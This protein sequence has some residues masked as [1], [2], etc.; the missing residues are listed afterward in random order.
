MTVDLVCIV[1][2]KSI[3][4]AIETLLQERK[5]SLGLGEFLFEIHVHPQR[6]PGCYKSGPEMLMSLMQQETTRGLLVFDHAWEGNPHPDAEATRLDVRRRLAALGDRAEVL[7]L[8]PELESWVWSG[9]PHVPKILGWSSKTPLRDWLCAHDLWPAHEPK[10]PDPKLAVELVLLETRIPRSSALYREL[11][12]KV[13]LARCSDPAF[14][15]LREILRRWFPASGSP[16]QR[17]RC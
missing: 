15:R 8:Q 16:P 5:A 14:A 9:S 13:G 6:D 1:A 12:R 3:E 11:A 7:V 17:T 2:D 10:P 4:A